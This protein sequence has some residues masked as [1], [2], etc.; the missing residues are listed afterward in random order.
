MSDI[1]LFRYTN[2]QVCELKGKQTTIEKSLQNLIERQMETILGI[3]FLASEYY[4][5]KIHKGRIDSLG[6][7]ENHCPVII[8]YKRATNENVINQGL[9]YLD[10]LMDHQA[11]FELLVIRKLGEKSSKNIEWSN[12]R[13]LCIASDFNRY[14]IHAVQQINRNTELIRYQLFHDDLLLLE[15]VNATSSDTPI[16]PP[17]TYG[18]T[19]LEYLNDASPEL[20]N[21]YDSLK[22]F[23]I[24]LGDDV[25]EKTLKH[26]IAFKRIKNF[27][28][29][30]IKPTA[31]KILIY[32]KVDPG[33]VSLDLKEGFVRD[34]CKIGHFG[35]G[36]LEVTI[37]NMDDL[38]RV[39]SL[40][41]TSYQN[42]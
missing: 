6:I 11:E 10:W 13:L 14:D 16:S 15:L 39:Q 36:N 37:K 12:P 31:D 22:N 38:V 19:V 5:G 26:Y 24:N 25:Q 33:S 40:I 34:V 42:S 28:C 41:E 17:S 8:E 18:K 7:D 2:D 3:H 9:F 1:K 32:L 20:K 23:I 30:E 29:V 27:A 35:T 4:T 21:L